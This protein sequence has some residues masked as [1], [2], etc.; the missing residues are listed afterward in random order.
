ME[1]GGKRKE[2]YRAAQPVF[3]VM[4]AVVDFVLL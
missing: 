1:T 3:L 2:M 4:I